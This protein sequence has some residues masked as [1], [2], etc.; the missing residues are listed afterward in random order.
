MKLTGELAKHYSVYYRVHCQTLGWLDWAK[1]GA[2]SGT[3]GYARRLEAIEIQLVDKDSMKVSGTAFLGQIPDSEISMTG[4]MVEVLPEPEPEDT[5]DSP[6][7]ILKEGKSSENTA[8]GSVVPEEKDVRTTANGEILGDI[9]GSFRM[10]SF[11][12]TRKP[13]GTDVMAGT[14]EYRAHCQTDGWKDWVSGGALCGTSGESKRLEAVQM[15]LTGSLGKLYDIYYRVYIEEFGWMGW[16]LNGASAGS[17]GYSLG[18]KAI[19]V[20]LV[21]KLKE[22]PGSDALAYISRTGTGMLIN[23]CPTAYISSE[24]GGR[25]S[26]T[27]GASSNHKGRDY[28]SPTGSAIYAASSGKVI[29][30][31][32]SNARGN[33]LILDHGNGLKTLY[34]HCSKIDVKVGQSVL[35][36]AKI[37]EVGSTGI[38]TGPHLH[39]EVWVKDVPVDPRLYL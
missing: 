5:E 33:Y 17:A 31:S 14:I 32:Y 10:E 25:V 23:P 12:I 20:Q 37:A 6:D 21:N 4:H 7:A 8:A 3:E 13:K 1:D 19:Q 30:V 36:G 29:T 16:T 22:G 24:F 35:V 26:P 27:A 2:S 34:Q 38:V 9:D 28:A 39:F 11:T 18:I 15:R